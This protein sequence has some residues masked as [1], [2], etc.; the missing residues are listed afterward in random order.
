RP[1]LRALLRE[2]TYLPDSEARTRLHHH[3][4][5]RFRKY[6]PRPS[7]VINR[8]PPEP[9]TPER[10]LS[11]LHNGQKSLN[12]LRRANQ[13]E[14]KALL[15]VLLWTYGRIGRR[16]RDLLSELLVPDPGTESQIYEASLTR[17]RTAADPTA[18]D[19]LPR[20][21]QAPTRKPDEY[22]R[23]LAMMRSQRSS[24]NQY[25]EKTKFRHMQVE[26]PLRNIWERPFP[27]KREK[28]LVRKWYATMLD[29]LVPPLPEEDWTRLRDLA[30]GA[31]KWEGVK[32][33]RARPTPHFSEN[34]VLDVLLEDGL[35]LKRTH[36]GLARVREHH[37]T[38]RL[39]RRMWAKVFERCP[40]M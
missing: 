23:L 9:F 28:N 31:R 40:V 24:N 34:A 6:T 36:K 10:L 15:N 38:E 32:P 39:M 25:A 13:G 14:D 5:Q 3:I 20:P 27:R 16:R 26:I 2:S 1:L 21:V 8:E 11:V 35:E 33:R 4:I 12:L 30:T 19:H 29:K 22:S 37:I 7:L 17:L 18:I